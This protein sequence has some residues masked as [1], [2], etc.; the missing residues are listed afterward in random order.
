MLGEAVREKI[1]S[2][3]DRYETKRAALLPALQIAQNTLGHVNLQAM[4]EIAELLDLQ[5]SEVY[6]TA[7]FYTHFWTTP[8]GRKTIV[9]CRSTSCALLNA[10]AVLQAFKDTLGIDEHQTTP[11]GE[12]SLM[13]E[14]CL[15]GCDHAPCVLINER[16][17]QRVKPED[18]PGLL[19]DPNNDKLDIPRST[20]FDPP[21]PGTT[22]PAGPAG[23][24]GNAAGG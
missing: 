2:F 22:P 21:R 8:K 6:D 14:E 10:E 18:V 23:E 1:R 9:C 24:A 20:L 16:L 17:H 15:A 7:S 12:Y 11:D 5:P 3:F 13:T 19:A 4:V